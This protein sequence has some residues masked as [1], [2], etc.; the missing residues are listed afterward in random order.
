[1][2]RIV[3]IAGAAALALAFSAGGPAAWAQS[4]SVAIAGWGPHPTLIETVDGFWKGM[5]A[6]GFVRGRNVTVEESHVNFDRSLIPQMLNKLA[7]GSPDLMVTIATPVS[8]TAVQTLRNRT[9]PIVFTPVADP[10]A[11]RLVPSWQAGDRLMT[12]SSNLPDHD[13]V[14]GFFQR[15]LPKMKRL[16][17]LYDTGD[18]SSV[19]AVEDLE[20][21]TKARGL[22]LV[23]IGVDN[24]SEIPQRVQSAVGQVD[25]LM[26]AASGRIQSALPAVAS[27]A[28]RTGLPIVGTVPQAVQQHAMLAAYSVSWARIGEEA[29]IMG[30]K[31]LKG[32]SPESL[33][34]WKPAAADHRPV[35]SGQRL[36]ALG[37]ALPEELKDC[38]CVIE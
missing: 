24:P 18:D 35:I 38:K 33:A 34:P 6:E 26:P 30:G 32:A 4:K 8:Q 3:H 10:V 27:V 23:K 17:I 12:G 21:V 19:A 31:I 20:R 29:G 25:A 11:A 15:L 28:N 2:R 36:K 22:A 7:A 14:V 16:G 1:M 13:A 9:F 37:L 5:E